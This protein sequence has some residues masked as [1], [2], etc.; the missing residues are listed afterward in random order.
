MSLKIFDGSGS[1]IDVLSGL[2]DAAFVPVS[3]TAWKAY[4]PIGRALRQDAPPEADPAWLASRGIA[5]EAL[6]VLRAVRTGV[7][8]LVR[9]LQADRGLQSFHFLVHDRTS[10]VP[11]TPEDTTSY[12]DLSLWFS[13]AVDAREWL[14]RPW[15]F[16]APRGRERAGSARALLDA[17]SAWYLSLVEHHRRL[18]DLDLLRQIRQSLHYFANMTQMQ[19]A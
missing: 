6:A 4:L 19:V 12:I 10:G 17:Q 13:R 16:V 1:A 7:L 11:T 3:A 18:G 14:P 15:C 5:L 9:T 8:P 2:R